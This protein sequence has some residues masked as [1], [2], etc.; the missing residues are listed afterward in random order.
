MFN[1]DFE[2]LLLFESILVNRFFD[3]S[4]SKNTIEDDDCSLDGDEFD[5]AAINGNECD[6]DDGN[7]SCCC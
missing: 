3:S 4:L 6:D 1:V 5:A 7:D 2:S